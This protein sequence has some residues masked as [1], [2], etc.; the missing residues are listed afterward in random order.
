MPRLPRGLIT[1]AALALA[2]S[3]AITDTAAQS[4]RGFLFGQPR[5]STTLRFGWAQPAAAGDLFAFTTDQLTLSRRDFGG[6]AI[7]ADFDARI[8]ARTHAVASIG[9]SRSASNSE[10]RGYIDNNNLPIE[11]NTTFARIPLSVGIKQYLTAPGQQV[12]RFAWIPARIAP[13]VGAGAGTMYYR[14]HQNGDFVDFQTLDVFTSQFT[15]SGWAPMAYARAG[16]E[17]TIGGRFALNADAR[18]VH[19]KAKPGNDFVGFSNIDLS[20]M[21]TTA[22]FTVRY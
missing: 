18:Y 7:D 11:Q 22:G 15:T 16:A 6:A 3:T 21:S 13:Y 14:F 10:V 1:A 19:A 20:G 4:G 9:W 2:T 17:F 5:F 12:G 8:V